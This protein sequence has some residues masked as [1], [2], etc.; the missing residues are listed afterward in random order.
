MKDAYSYYYGGR[1]YAGMLGRLN[2]DDLDKVKEKKF[3]CLNCFEEVRFSG[4]VIINPYF[5][6][7]PGSKCVCGGSSMSKWHKGWQD[8]FDN[9]EVDYIFENLS[10][11]RADVS[12]YGY[13]IIELQNSKI[14][15]EKFHERNKNYSKYKSLIWLFNLEKE[16][17]NIVYNEKTKMYN[18]KTMWPC[19]RGFDLKYYPN[20]EIY[21]Q[22]YENSKYDKDIYKVGYFNNKNGNHE[23]KVLKTMSRKQFINE[24]SN[25]GIPVVLKLSDGELKDL[26][27]KYQNNDNNIRKYMYRYCQ[28]RK[29]VVMKDECESCKYHLYERKNHYCYYVFDKLIEGKEIE[30]I[31]LNHEK[32]YYADGT[33]DEYCFNKYKMDRT[34]WQLY[35]DYEFDKLNHK[36]KSF[37]VINTN[38]E[39][40]KVEI[41]NKRWIGYKPGGNKNKEKAEVPNFDKRIWRLL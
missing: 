33:I 12:L 19:F 32:I 24:V 38:G 4:S 6:H 31:D 14:T 17:N 2:Q 10:K 11:N 40:Y 41:D 5:K 26:I 21:L 8:E 34:I 20:V 39:I 16:T 36:I 29:S 1:V 30:K 3:I 22:L 28:M 35:Y 18:W 25:V 13:R 7:L 9:T 15:E 37:N 23:I 27:Y